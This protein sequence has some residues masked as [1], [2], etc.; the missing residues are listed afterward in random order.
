MPLP[1]EIPCTKY[2]SVERMAE[3]E[4]Y[5]TERLQSRIRGLQGIRDSKI[6]TWRR[7][8]A[9][10]PR[11]K[12]K[13]FPWQNASNVIVK[14]VRSF[15][16]QLVAKIVMGSIAMEPPFE[17]DLVGIFQQ[18]ER[19]EDMRMAI[20]EWMG[21]Q[22]LEPHKLNLVPKY[23]IWTRNFVKYGF[24]ALKCLPEL[25]VEQVAASVSENGKGVVFTDHVRHDGP[26]VHPIMFEDFLM[27]TT[28]V[29]LIR[30]PAIFHRAIME[31][32][33]MEALKH[34]P[35]YNKKEVE[36]AIKSPTR[37]GP[38]KQRRE[39]ED[40][41]GARTDSSEVDAQWDVYECYFPYQVQDKTFRLISTC[42][43]DDQGMTPVFLKHVFNWLP[44]NSLPF[45]GGWLA[46]DGERSYTPGFCELLSDYQEEVSAIHNRRGDASTAANTNIFRISS[47]Q[48][49]DSQ[50][51]IYPMAMITADKDGFEVV[52]LGRDARETIKDEQMTLQEA[53][54]LV[55]IGPSS[56]GSGAGTVNKKGAYS[57]MGT[58]ATMQEGNTRPNLNI[59]EF[60]TSHYS[61]GRLLLLYYS[62]FGVSPEDIKSLGKQ[63]PFL[64]KA[65]E[66]VKDR[67]IAL[68]IKAATGSVN[69]EIEKQNLMLLLN[70][71][72]AH[73]QMVNQLLQTAANPMAPEVMQ[74]YVVRVILASNLL[75]TKICRD[76]GVPDPSSIL[77][78][79]RG[80]QEKADA[81]EA[82][83]QRAKA[84]QKMAQ[85]TQGG[86]QGGQPANAQ[87]PQPQSPGAPGEPT[88]Q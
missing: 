24:G 10:T 23:T 42:V 71:T 9:G 15:A 40:E 31:R 53:Q 5:I 64:E 47:G 86:G 3:I 58:F 68:P 16:D 78:E 29:E 61:L 7:I 57:A 67:R 26:V 14:V 19:A 21:L 35:S 55:G 56:S 74:D 60:R 79:P 73:W 30:D 66:A 33:Q 82:Q 52:A 44:E 34:D 4:T 41:T 72:R 75:M 70:N 1:T 17:A 84:L 20:Q 51:S 13:S 76:F 43:A 18:T 2:F 37:L 45:I 25:R 81:A 54:D 46:P 38:T 6:S 11:E 36:K 22:S 39:M 48:Q 27:A 63:G 85:L 77:P 49:L 88:M 83:E 65:L 62:H 8:Y 87:V 69:K 12:T 32:F 28:T 59:T 50:Y 80:L